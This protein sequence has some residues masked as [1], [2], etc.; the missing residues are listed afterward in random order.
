MTRARTIALA[1]ASLL[2]LAPPAPRETTPRL[3]PIPPLALPT[4]PVH[5]LPIAL[6]IDERMRGRSKALRAYRMGDL[7]A[8][9]ERVARAAFASVEVVETADD[10]DGQA[11]VLTASLAGSG[12]AAPIGDVQDHRTAVVLTWTLV[13]GDGCLVWADTFV[14]HGE[15]SWQG[16][17]VRAWRDAIEDSLR[18]A[19]RALAKSPDIAAY[20]QR[21]RAENRASQPAPSDDCPV[22]PGDLGLSGES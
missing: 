3:E 19:H 20:A 14:G 16:S 12:H 5:E 9:L 18:A 15:Q 11:G 13:D 6:V 4:L 17:V 7:A 1:A 22:D 2:C 21:S 8:N 10:R